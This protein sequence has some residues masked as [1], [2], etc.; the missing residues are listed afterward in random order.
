MGRLSRIGA[1]VGR[2]GNNNEMTAR[3]RRTLRS[4]WEPPHPGRT[5]GS[6]D[7]LETVQGHSYE[8]WDN[9]GELTRGCRQVL[10]SFRSL[11][12]NV[13]HVVRLSGYT[14]MKYDSAQ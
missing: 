5:L 7:G 14:E 2:I 4:L 1:L 11:G 10:T 6:S 8:M 12:L 13:R 3:Y 9:D